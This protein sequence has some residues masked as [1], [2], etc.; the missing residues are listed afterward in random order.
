MIWLLIRKLIFA[1]NKIKE[2]YKNHIYF[3]PKKNHVHLL[4]NAL[5]GDQLPAC[6]RQRTTTISFKFGVIQDRAR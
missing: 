3:L 5:V 6:T 1:K 4:S 2:S